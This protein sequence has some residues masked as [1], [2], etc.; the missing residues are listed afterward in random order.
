VD[1]GAASSLLPG[2]KPE[3]DESEP[4]AM[5]GTDAN[6]VP[7][8]SATQNAAEVIAYEFKSNAGKIV[9]TNEQRFSTPLLE[10]GKD[11]PA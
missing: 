7:F 3:P 1:V 2:L 4:M 9:A 10:P 11:G 5:T 6:T 8:R